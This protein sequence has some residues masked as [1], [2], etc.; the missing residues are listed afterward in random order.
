VYCANDIQSELTFGRSD[1]VH[2]ALLLGCDYTDG[3]K[4]VGI[5]N[6]SEIV[7]HWRGVEGLQRWAKWMNDSTT[8]D[9]IDAL[10]AANDDDDEGGEEEEEEE[11]EEEEE[12]E[13]EKKGKKKKTKTKKRTRKRTKLSASQITALTQEEKYMHS[14]RKKRTKWVVPT[15]YPSHALR[16][17]FLQPTVD[18]A[19]PNFAWRKRAD[20]NRARVKE[21][22]AA[23]LGWSEEHSARLLDKALDGDARLAGGSG[24][25][26]NQLTLESYFTRYDD[27]MTA[28]APKSKRLRAA[29]NME[30]PS[31]EEE[32]EEEEEESDGE[33]SAVEVVVIE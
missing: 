13:G 25:D 8:P 23:K 21:Y 17:A 19:M 6:A 31:E 27:A 12:E 26:A 16:Q 3:V 10:L 29:F 7:T 32:E 1:L 5:V 11:D 22:C 2:V 15:D 28:P 20:V 30:D 24:G 14:H 9:A 4:G 33:G 18:V